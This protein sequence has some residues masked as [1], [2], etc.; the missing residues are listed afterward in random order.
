[1]NGILHKLS[2]KSIQ[3]TINGA[4]TEIVAQ[5]YLLVAFSLHCYVFFLFLLNITALFFDQQWFHEVMGVLDCIAIICYSMI[6][7]LFLPTI[8]S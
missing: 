4:V 3:H 2:R 7:F 5:Q 8:E 6:T 1:L